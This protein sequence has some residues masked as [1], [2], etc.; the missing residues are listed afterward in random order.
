MPSE[1]NCHTEAK[2]INGDGPDQFSA[3]L[4]GQQVT[5]SCDD[6]YEMTK[7]ATVSCLFSG[8]WS[9]SPPKC[10]GKRKRKLNMGSLLINHNYFL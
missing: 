10:K 8:S 1:T 3:Y 5:Y 9:S 6:G 2:P 4:P 7:T